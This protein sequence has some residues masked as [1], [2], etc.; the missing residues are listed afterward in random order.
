MKN[1][2][3]FK[4]IILGICLVSNPNLS[5]AI[6]IGINPT[7]QSVSVGTLVDVEVSISGLGNNSSPSLRLFNLTLN[8]EPSILALKSHSFGGPILGDQLDLGLGPILS[9]TLPPLVGAVGLVVTGLP[10]LIEIFEFS[11][12]SSFQLDSLQA[13]S[14]TLFTLTFNILDLGTSPLTLEVRAL[15]DFLGNP[16]IASVENGSVEVTQAP[17]PEPGTLILFGSGIFGLALWRFS[18]RN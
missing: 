15:E 16:F 9:P 10:G 1:K 4:L 18:P 2:L 8:F 12:R 17:V 11:N 7:T 13:G 14:F 6:S 5:Q 3:F